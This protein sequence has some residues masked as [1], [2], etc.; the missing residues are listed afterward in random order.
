MF[1]DKVNGLQAKTPN[2]TYKDWSSY[3]VEVKYEYPKLFAEGSGRNL[4]GTMIS[5]FI[6]VFPKITCQ[7]GPLDKTTLETDIIPI[8]DSPRQVIKYYDPNKKT[9]VEMTTYTG[10]YSIV[11]KNVIGNGALNEGFDISFIAVSKRS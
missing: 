2:G 7:F 5:D 4:S 9:Y 6:G 11:N 1:K 10:D 8:I 3:L